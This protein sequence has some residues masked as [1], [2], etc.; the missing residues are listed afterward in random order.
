MTEIKF[1]L[2]YSHDE[3]SKIC[4]DILRSLPQWFGIESAI[5][6]YVNDVEKM[7]TWIASINDAPIGFIAINKHNQY[8][9]EIHVMGILEDYHNKKIGSQ[10]IQKASDSLSKEGFTYL[11]VKTLSESREDANY[12]KTRKFYLKNGFLP[13]EEFKTLWGEENPCLLLIKNIPPTQ[14]KNTVQ[15]IKSIAA[16]MIH[17]PDWK[18]GLAWY[19]K[20]FPEAKF[21]SLPEFDFKCLQLNG[22]NI[23]VVKADEKVGSGTYG[24]AVDWEA[25]DFDLT[26]NHFVSLGATLYRGPMNIEG[27]RRMCKLKDPFGNLLG[28]RGP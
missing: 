1:T 9:A 16:I 5:V 23:E 6:D 3:K 12:A 2:L 28:L 7:D 8:T 10:L 25:S 21:I 24:I 13:V 26:F 17:V 19:Q 22:I 14:N 15:S 11:S 4:N 18:E 20:A 27:G